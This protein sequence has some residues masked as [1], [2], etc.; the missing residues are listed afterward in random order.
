MKVI[1]ER[2]GKTW[3]KRCGNCDSLLEYEESDIYTVERDCGEAINERKV[4]GFIFPKIIKETVPTVQGVKC[5]RCPVCGRDVIVSS[6]DL[7]PVQKGTYEEV[8]TYEWIW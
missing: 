8:G 3:Q 6:I 1:E 4:K 2:H 7:F 5:V